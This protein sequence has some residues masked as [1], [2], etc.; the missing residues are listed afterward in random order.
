MHLAKTIHLRLWASLVLWLLASTAQSAL[1]NVEPN[2]WRDTQ[3]NLEWLSVSETTTAALG[4]TDPLDEFSTTTVVDIMAAV[5]LTDYMVNQGFRVASS[6]EVTGLYAGSGGVLDFVDNGVTGPNL[7]PDVFDMGMTQYA[8]DGIPY[9]TNYDAI[10]QSGLHAGVAPDSIVYSEVVLNIITSFDAQPNYI[11]DGSSY[12]L[13]GSPQ[14]D[15]ASYYYPYGGG[16]NETSVYLVRTV[17][18]PPAVW[19]FGSGLIALWRWR[20][21]S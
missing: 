14:A 10:I 8:D 1:V 17:P 20:K 11:V 16:A 2:V 18:I 9:G 15:Y 13:D 12:L 4:L 19:L 3:T 6:T 5:A 21:P 7:A